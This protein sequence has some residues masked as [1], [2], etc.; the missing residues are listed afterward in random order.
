MD[1]SGSRSCERTIHPCQEVEGTDMST[2]HP[3]GY[4]I[5][6]GGRKSSAVGRSPFLPRFS[7]R[8]SNTVTLLKYKGKL[9]A[10]NK[11]AE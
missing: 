7:P 1:L 3:E 9:L 6:R 4:R 10:R 2:E 5:P 8:L 11:R